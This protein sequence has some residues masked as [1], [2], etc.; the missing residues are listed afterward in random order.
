ML[1][2]RIHDVWVGMVA[3]VCGKIVYDENSYILYRQ[4]ENNVVGAK[5]MT[6]LQLLEDKVKKADFI[7]KVLL[8]FF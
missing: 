2:N 5:D 7:F 8:N 6:S 1:K 3:S 4:H